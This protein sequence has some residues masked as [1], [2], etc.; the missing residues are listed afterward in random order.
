M[1]ET[2]IILF[3]KYLDG[4]LSPTERIAFENQLDENSSLK[5]DFL[6]YQEMN[7]FLSQK[8]QN[9]KA[10]EAIAAT[11][12]ELTIRSR[13]NGWKKWIYLLLG[14]LLIALAAYFYDKMFQEKIPDFYAHYEAP[15]WPN[16]RGNND[17]LSYAIQLYLNENP[18]LGIQQLSAL[19]NPS[20]DINYWIAEMHLQQ[21]NFNLCLRFL[22]KAKGVEGRKERILFMKALCFYTK[23]DKAS[24]KKLKH[25]LPEEISDYYRK[26]IM[27]LT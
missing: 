23:R 21:E 17:V 2:R 4:S 27:S 6:L 14:I 3:D 15:I 20:A 8:V 16:E 11:R 12:D 10:L 22:E 7:G 26:R 1:E 9:K 13:N 19:D 5:E 25:A 18:E 24:L